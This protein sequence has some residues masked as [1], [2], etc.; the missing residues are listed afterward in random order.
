MSIKK[1]HLILLMEDSPANRL[2][3]RNAVGTDYSVVAVASAR[4]AHE[5]LRKYF[6]SLVVIDTAL[7]DTDSFEVCAEIKKDHPRTQVVFLSGKPA[8]SHQSD[9]ISL[10]A[11]YILKPFSPS[12]LKNRIETALKSVKFPD[13]KDKKEIWPSSVDQEIVNQILERKIPGGYE[14]FS[15]LVDIFVPESLKRV[16]QI[17]IYHSDRNTAELAAEAH[18]LK[19]SCGNLGLKRMA[20]ICQKI[21]AFADAGDLVSVT[22]LLTDLRMAF[23]QTKTA[24]RFVGDKMAAEEAE[25][26]AWKNGVPPKN[27]NVLVA[28]DD[29]IIVRTL[30]QVLESQGYTFSGVSNGAE[31]L[32]KLSR[33]T[34]DLVITDANM[35]NG[36]S[37]FE[38]AAA[39]SKSEKMMGIPIILL[40]GRRSKQDVLRAH[41]CGVDDYVVKPVDPDMILAKIDS[42]LKSGKKNQS[43][44]TKAAS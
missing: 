44:G 15:Q 11:D 24:L 29:P 35:P 6:Y 13:P 41:E 3:F 20:E 17:L 23:A 40:T 31:A 9:K 10:A 19:S 28:D 27:K 43:K 38:L 8:A 1:D 26:A 14:L 33:R 22:P 4:E 34:Y 12:D 2:L 7:P 36:M 39:M 18:A 21:D 16:N 25:M 37:G 5:E 32:E 30:K 42:L